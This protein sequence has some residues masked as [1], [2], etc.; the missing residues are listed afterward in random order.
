MLLNTPTVR[1]KIRDGRLILTKSYSVSEVDGQGAEPVLTDG[2]YFGGSIDDLLEVSQRASVPVLRKDFILDEVQI[3]EARAA[4]AAAVLL[5]VRALG[6]RL[7]GLLRFAEDC[8]LDALV[9][10]HTEDELRKALDAG[11]NILGVNSRDLDTFAIVAKP[12]EV[13][14]SAESR[15]GESINGIAGGL[16]GRQLQVLVDPQR[17]QNKD[18]TLSQVVRTAGNAQIVSPL[19]F[20]EASTPGS[21][22]FTS[23]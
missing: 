15:Y 5:I 2:P 6:N 11:A 4:G 18:V 3:L 14:K 9:E 7:T 10:V 23:R 19:S 16:R 21:G 20:L 22:G 12:D 17:L 8:G 13:S 1:D